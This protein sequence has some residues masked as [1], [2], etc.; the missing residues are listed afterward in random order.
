MHLLFLLMS[1]ILG[2]P[3]VCTASSTA[4]GAIAQFREAGW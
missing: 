2:G 3:L 4:E 1:F